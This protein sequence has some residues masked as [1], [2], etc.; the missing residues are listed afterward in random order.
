MSLYSEQKGGK[1]R[2]R[3]SSLDSVIG[4]FIYQQAQKDNQ[5][6]ACSACFCSWL[7]WP[8]NLS[9]SFQISK[10]KHWLNPVNQCDMLLQIPRTWE[11]SPWPP[12]TFPETLR[13]RKR[14]GNFSFPM[15]RPSLQAHTVC[16]SHAHEMWLRVKSS[17]KALHGNVFVCVSAMG[18]LELH[19]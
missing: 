3:V 2:E 16:L 13:P 7:L 14:C 15:V 5:P 10:I 1:A 6:H 17:F 4:V 8:G 19:G 9:F 11:V 12:K 18:K